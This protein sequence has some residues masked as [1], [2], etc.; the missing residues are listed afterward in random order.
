MRE[1]ILAALLV[2]VL[3]AGA[4]AE[5]LKR[6]AATHMGPITFPAK[7]GEVTFDHDRHQPV[8]QCATCHDNLPSIADSGKAFAHKFCLGCHQSLDASF[9][10]PT[11][12]DGC[13]KK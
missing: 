1:T 5:M 2:C 11:M 6:S 13:H 9:Q 8:P 3:A 12:C 4:S 7:N 10:A